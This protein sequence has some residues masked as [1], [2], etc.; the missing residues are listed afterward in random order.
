MIALTGFR[1]AAY[2]R[3]HRVFQALLPIL[4]LLG[5]LH[6]SRA[7]R[8]E[9]A[10]ALTDAAVLIIPF[11]AWAARS[12]LD[13]EPDDQRVISATSVGGHGREVGAGL[14]AALSVTLVF[15]A[16][17]LASSL[18]L[19]LEALPD[20]PVLTAAIIL[21]VLAALAGVALGALTSRP[22]LPSPAL[23]IMALVLGFLAMLLLSAT[24]AY[25]L[26]I[27]VT[28]WMKSAGHGALTADLPLLAA[29]SLAWCLAGLAG[30]VRLRRTRP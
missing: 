20:A 1:V 23:S 8:G 17:T 24:P 11:L 12:L 5:I 30:Y 15:S 14:L 21:H 7:P 10:A 25:W 6:A 16:L 29:V 18:F 9:E 3:S 27:P 22:I 4:A 28:A 2:L 19:G 13:T 26:T